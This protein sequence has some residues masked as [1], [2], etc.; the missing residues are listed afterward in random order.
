MNC[1]FCKKKMTSIFSHK[2]GSFCICNA[3]LSRIPFYFSKN[4]DSYSYEEI[5]SII[6]WEH[7]KKNGLKQIFFTTSSYGY[8]HIDSLHHLIAIG[9]AN[10]FE[11][12][13]PVNNDVLIIEIE[14]MN[15]V[16]F[17]VDVDRSSTEE[18]NGSILMSIAVDVP[19][20][21]LKNVLIKKNETIIPT[22]ANENSVTFSLPPDVELIW[23]EIYEIKEQLVNHD[24]LLSGNQRDIDRAMGLYMVEDEFT[25]DQLK[26][27][28]N[29]LMKAFH[30]DIDTTEGADERSQFVIKAYE[31][32]K[33]FAK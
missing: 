32:L 26:K 1:S 7:E 8:L 23:N 22:M 12:G 27:Q 5:S 2:A 13:K 16:S 20:I 3:C 4:L 21:E 19:N 15:N 29:I 33:P 24:F 14:N 25:L 6:E 9:N 17:D 30:P 10:D 28:R 18:I 31:L 11:K